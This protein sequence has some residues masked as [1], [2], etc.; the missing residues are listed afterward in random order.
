M[1]KIW[2]KLAVA[3][4]VLILCLALPVMVSA[5]EQTLADVVE[6]DVLDRHLQNEYEKRFAYSGAMSIDLSEFHIPVSMA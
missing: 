3:L 5:S 4:S 1:K 2:G 6:L